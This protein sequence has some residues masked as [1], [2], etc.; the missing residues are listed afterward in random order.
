MD[1]YLLLGPAQVHTRSSVKNRHHFW[2]TTLEIEIFS[3]ERSNQKTRRADRRPALPQTSFISLVAFEWLMTHSRVKV[4]DKGDLVMIS[5]REQFHHR[6]HGSHL[7]QKAGWFHPLGTTWLEWANSWRICTTYCRWNNPLSWLWNKQ[8]CQ[9]EE[10]QKKSWSKLHP[11]SDNVLTTST[12]PLSLFA[13]TVMT[14]FFKGER[15][16]WLIPQGWN[17]V[18]GFTPPVDTAQKMLV[19]LGSG[20][21]AANACHYVPTMLMSYPPTTLARLL[22][23]FFFP[24]RPRKLAPK[25][26]GQKIVIN[27][28][29]LGSK[30][31]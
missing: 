25:R 28:S 1:S 16:P 17:R 5:A 14:L 9:E 24:V 21:T 7:K 11:V 13:P 8:V 22:H 18:S 31:D 6:D 3:L 2:L 29:F 15:R 12:P 20:T 4:G 19:P 27:S 23:F 26:D 30:A 10:E